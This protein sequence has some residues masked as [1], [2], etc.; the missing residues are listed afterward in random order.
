MWNILGIQGG[1]LSQFIQPIYLN[2]ILIG[3]NFD[4]AS[5]ERALVHRTSSIVLTEN[6][7]QKGYKNVSKKLNIVQSIILDFKQTAQDD[8]SIFWYKGRNVVGHIVMGFK[9]GSKKPVRGNKFG[10]ALQS[11]LSRQCIFEFF[12][13]KIKYK[14]TDSYIDEKCQSLDYQLA[15]KIFLDSEIFKSWLVRNKGI[16]L[17]RDS[18][19]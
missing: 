2:S 8:T 9:K 3:A 15:K 17:F 19:L 16:K 5:L 13:K 11:P 18:C 10:L 7:I 4:R 1:L 14:P 12:F 6:L